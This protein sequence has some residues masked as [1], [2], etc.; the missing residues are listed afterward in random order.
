M[1]L[2]QRE[3]MGALQATRSTKWVAWVGGCPDQTPA[4]PQ[5]EP[6]RAGPRHRVRTGCREKFPDGNID[7]GQGAGAR[8]DM[9]PAELMVETGACGWKTCD[10]ISIL[11]EP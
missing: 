6:S 10:S 5:P 7:A 4:S 1:E 11:A 8:L 2:R 9:Q 3:A